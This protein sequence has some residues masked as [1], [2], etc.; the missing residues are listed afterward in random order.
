[1]IDFN[2]YK[3]E[4]LKELDTVKDYPPNSLFFSEGLAVYSL[5]K[6]FK[7]D[8]LI[9]SGVFRGGSTS[10]WIRTLKDISIQCYDILESKRHVSI[11][12]G[13]IDKYQ[14]N[15]NINFTIGDGIIE[16]PKFIESNPDKRIGVF[17]DGPKDRQG[18]DLCDKCLSY[19][20]VFF[21]CLHD[22]SKLNDSKHLST[23]TS[24]KFNSVAGDMNA[25]HPQ[26]GKYPNGPGL[27]C[28]TKEEVL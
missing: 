28:I 20:N 22:F 27:Y 5:A 13:V 8:I 4:Y 11:V 3:K 6:Y 25:Q 1:M 16:I 14:D 24:S 19:N 18:L 12:Q 9:E 10:I 26:I 15:P 23:R 21:S 17:V 7:I 2:Y